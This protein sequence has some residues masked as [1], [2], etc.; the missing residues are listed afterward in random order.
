M[1]ARGGHPVERFIPDEEVHRYLEA[2][3]VLLVPRL[4]DRRSGLPTEMCSGLVP[5]ALMFGKIVIAPSHSA[6]PECLGGTENPLYEPGDPASLARAIEE[7]RHARPF[8]HRDGEPSAGSDLELLRH[9]AH[10]P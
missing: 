10:S 1:K 6:H 7:R 9:R 5:L 8:A 4:P 3:D 2:A